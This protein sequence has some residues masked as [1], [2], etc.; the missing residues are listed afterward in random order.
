V[1]AGPAHAIVTQILRMQH[2]VQCVV[3]CGTNQRLRHAIE[4]LTLPHA[5]RFRV[6]GLTTDMVNLVRVA[7]LFVG[8]PGGLTAAECMA[9]GTPM[10]M[11][12]PIPGQEERNADYLLEEGAAVR[13]NDLDIIDYKLDQLLRDPARLDQLR[14][15]ARRVG[16]PD[17]A[18]VI[19]TTALADRRAPAHF[20]WPVV[21]PATR[22][23]GG[24]MITRRRWDAT[25]TAIEL[26]DDARGVH[27]GTVTTHHFRALRRVLRDFDG[28]TGTAT[29]TMEHVARLRALGADPRVCDTIAA[30]IAR[31]G[32]LRM[33]RSNVHGAQ[34]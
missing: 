8:K 9:A 23:S 21:R 12:T 25:S 10:L 5:A 11:V 29:L 1:G 33:R 17:A 4:T 32:P 20:A 15:N 27:L 7:T 31:F 18:Q 24:R 2:A 3:I 6:L 16:R 30:R 13:C 14:R 26:Y 19:A 34:W 22:G 28:H